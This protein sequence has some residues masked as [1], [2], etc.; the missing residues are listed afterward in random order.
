MG[1]WKGW[2]EEHRREP[3]VARLEQRATEVLSR[4]EIADGDRI[5]DIGTGL[6]LLAAAEAAASPSGRVVGID[7]SLEVMAACLGR[8]EV[9]A[10]AAADAAA[11]PFADAS[12]DVVTTFCV[13]VYV[14]EK[15]RTIEECFRVLRPGGRVSLLEPVHQARLG[16]HEAPDLDEFEPGHSELSAAHT[17]LLAEHGAVLASF[18]ADTL[19]RWF[20]EAG[21]DEVRLTYELS[22]RQVRASAKA[23]RASL[24]RSPFPGFP[25]LA[26]EAAVRLGQEASARYLD[27]YATR[28]AAAPSRLV[29]ATATLSARKPH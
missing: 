28:L 10:G 1:G 24:E 8:H 3:E 5:L 9:L 7:R 20:V 26:E 22:V 13:L 6:G 15:V 19:A 11:L 2:L 17:R 4:A 18:D 27:A 23:H 29:G 25:S 21:F 12:F 16:Y 14:P